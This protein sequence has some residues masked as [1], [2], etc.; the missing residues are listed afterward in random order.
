MAHYIKCD[1][2]DPDA[3][4]AAAVEIREKLGAPSILI[5]N[6]GIGHDFPIFDIPPQRVKKLLEVNL[7]SHWSASLLQFLQLT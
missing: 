2:T 4:D 6:A 3:V 5:N 1:V 7:I